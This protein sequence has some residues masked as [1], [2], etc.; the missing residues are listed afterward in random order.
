[1]ANMAR[2]DELIAALVAASREYDAGKAIEDA[3]EGGPYLGS[4]LEGV[5]RRQCPE[6]FDACIEAGA[7]V[8]ELRFAF[9]EES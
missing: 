7:T 5:A 8:E 9:G 3:G 4:I 6:L 1:M 2:K